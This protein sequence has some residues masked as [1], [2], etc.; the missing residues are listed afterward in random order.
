M[1]AN[2]EQETGLFEIAQ[3]H[4]QRALEPPGA[5]N[6]LLPRRTLENLLLNRIV[7]PFRINNS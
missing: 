3:T 6:L 2:K 1:K 7:E 5:I 4:I